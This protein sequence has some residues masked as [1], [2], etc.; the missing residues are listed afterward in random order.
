MKKKKKN[1][2]KIKK[3][4]TEIDE[5]NMSVGPLVNHLVEVSWVSRSLGGEGGGEDVRKE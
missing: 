1:R 2:K 4:I 3:K 5:E